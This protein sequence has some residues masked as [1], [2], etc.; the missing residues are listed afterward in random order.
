M[1]SDVIISAALIFCS[2]S[3]AAAKFSLDCK[4]PKGGVPYKAEVTNNGTMNRSVQVTFSKKPSTAQ[5]TKIVQACVVAAAAEDR[6]VDALGSAW[7]ADRAINL[8]NGRYYAYLAG[9]RRYQFM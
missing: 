7:V 9:K 1:K 3:A 2:G 4:A 5:A 6:S 8:S